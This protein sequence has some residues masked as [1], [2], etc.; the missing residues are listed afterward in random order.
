MLTQEQATAAFEKDKAALKFYCLGRG[1]HDPLKA[2][3]FAGKLH[4]GLRK[5]GVTPEF[6]HQIRIAFSIINLRDV[7]NEERC[8]TLALLHDTAED[9]DIPRSTLVAEFSEDLA[10]EVLTPDKNQFGS[11]E[12]CMAAIAASVNCSVVK[13]ADNVDN[14]QS[15]HG[16][17]SVEKIGKYIERTEAKILPMLKVASANFPEQHLAYSSLR[18]RLRSQIELYRALTTK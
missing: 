16:A 1:Y 4:T 9:Y 13:G 7:V 6:H 2:L 12:R 14:I 18:Y 3:A 15:M 5:D 8:L 10:T 17:F 11:E